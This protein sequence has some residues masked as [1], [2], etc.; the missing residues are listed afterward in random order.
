MEQ[1]R[2][3]II[4]KMS[5]F[6]NI[7][8]T[9]VFFNSDNGD[10]LTI[11]NE[12]YFSLTSGETY[13]S[14]FVLTNLI[15]F[16][17]I[18]NLENKNVI[19]LL[20]KFFGKKTADLRNFTKKN[21]FSTKND[22]FFTKNNEETTK[23]NEKFTEIYD[24]PTELLFKI[25]EKPNENLIKVSKNGKILGINSN[26]KIHLH[27]TLI[28]KRAYDFDG[29]IFNLMNNIELNLNI[30]LKNNIEQINQPEVKLFH[31]ECIKIAYSKLP[32]TIK[33]DELLEKYNKTTT[34]IRNQGKGLTTFANNNSRK[35]SKR[36]RNKVL[37]VFLSIAIV[38]ITI[39]FIV[40]QISNSI[41]STT[42]LETHSQIFTEAEIK[43]MITNYKTKT[44]IEFWEFRN[45]LIIN[46]MKD[47]EITEERAFF[48]IDSIA[49]EKPKQDD[50]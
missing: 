20:T 50:K 24:M 12:T 44:G 4:N 37:L 43:V 40:K 30:I 46:S 23:I 13:P 5:K 7:I 19:N 29:D 25:N 11:N 38:I 42:L 32:F 15:S 21:D 1:L 18:N 34:W 49:K 9:S 31:K 22:V 27:N 6:Q 45:G 14:D 17:E 2:S 10:Y 36:I 16:D 8:N 3:E 39:S 41:N 47:I 35:E 33:V 28:L 48:I 26:K